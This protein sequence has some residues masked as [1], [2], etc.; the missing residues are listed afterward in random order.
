M[1]IQETQ[2]APGP[3][4]PNTCGPDSTDWLVQQIVMARKN[5]KVLEV[6]NKIDTANFFAPLIMP[7]TKLNAMDMLEGQELNMIAKAWDA[8]GRPQPTADAN[9]QLGKP[10][11]VLGKLELQTAM[12][13]K[14]LV[15]A[16][17]PYDFK[18]DASTMANPKS[19]NCP[20]V[21]C[22]KTITL[23]PGSPGIN[24][25]EKDFPGNVLYAHVGAFAGFSETPG[26]WDRSGHNCSQAG[27]NIG[28]RLPI[29][30]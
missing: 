18:L 28:I 6:R 17:R 14:N 4:Q 20:D 15:G 23:C 1:T 9:Q 11:A 3:P 13:W 24:C 2:P 12:G 5:A 30:R 16:G 26:S 19:A 8:T 25:F 27:G 7:P 22:G 21:N 10:S 29:H